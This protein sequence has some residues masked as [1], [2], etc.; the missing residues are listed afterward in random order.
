MECSICLEVVTFDRSSHCCCSLPCGHIFGMKC[1]RKWVNQ[2]GNCPMCKTVARQTDIHQLSGPS[3]GGM[4]CVGL[5]EKAIVTKSELASMEHHTDFEKKDANRLRMTSSI[6]DAA[7]KKERLALLQSGGFILSHSSILL[8]LMSRNG[9]LF[10]S[11]SPLVA[12]LDNVLFEISPSLS[13][14]VIL[15][16]PSSSPSFQNVDSGAVGA[17]EKPL[18]NECRSQICP[19]NS[20]EV[21]FT[22][23]SVMVFSGG[24]SP[25]ATIEVEE[26]V[27]AATMSHDRR[28][29][30]IGT[31][32]GMLLTVS[33]ET[34]CVVTKQPCPVER[35][36]NA[37]L[38][39]RIGSKE[40]L[41]FAF[42]EGVAYLRNGQSGW[43]AKDA[44]C[45]KLLWTE[46]CNTITLLYPSDTTGR[47]V[48]AS[49]RASTF[50]AVE[51]QEADLNFADVQHAVAV[52]SKSTITSYRARI[53]RR[54][55]S[56][57]FSTPL[58]TDP[59]VEEITEDV[60][61]IHSD[62]RYRGIVF[63]R[64]TKFPNNT[65]QTVDVGDRVIGISYCE[66][67]IAVSTPTSASLFLLA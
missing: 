47:T 32:E 1:I 18:A 23:G 45:A 33:S 6:L 50:P 31:N 49:V 67:K 46:Y 26:T 52:P 14:K 21:F 10:E 59:L 17:K 19:G 53:K 35:K 56:S 16:H 54:H 29:I 60:I 5:E 65:K 57:S 48:V 61:L 9:S 34:R 39:V 7:L 42:D 36:V 28:N 40:T 38:C 8:P 20:P 3:V 13:T 58:I 30:A 15:R 51:N 27:T 24:A 4:E 25:L 2:S 62:T 63:A 55:I 37:L 22:S 11:T 44:R 41:I 66:G 12:F 64:S 43:L